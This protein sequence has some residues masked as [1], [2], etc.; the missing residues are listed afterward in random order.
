M[1]FGSNNVS[2]PRFS[3][4]GYG[5]YIKVYHNSDYTAREAEIIT[6]PPNL[7]GGI[8]IMKGKMPILF[9]QPNTII[10]QMDAKE[11]LAEVENEVKKNYS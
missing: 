4:G 2:L 8:H 10:F 3:I 5:F 7:P 1:I 6:D 11:L 9:N